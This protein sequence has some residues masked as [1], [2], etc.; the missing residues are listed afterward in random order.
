MTPM[1]IPTDAEHRR[2]LLNDLVSG[3]ATH[4]HLSKGIHLSALKAGEQLGLALQIA[5]RVLQAG[6]FQRVLE[7]RFEQALAF[8]GCFV[9][10]NAGGALILWHPVV[11]TDI[12]LDQILSRLLS[13]AELEALDRH[14]NR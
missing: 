9:F 13:L 1:E 12:P 11:S 7:R 14:C 6:Q 10:S 3:A 4:L 2:V 5:P 8:E